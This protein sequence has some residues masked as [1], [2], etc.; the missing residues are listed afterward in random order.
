M[1]V[2]PAPVRADGQAACRE[3]R[4]DVKPNGTNPTPSTHSADR[5]APGRGEP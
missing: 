3:L 1:L 4:Y 5:Q 2:A